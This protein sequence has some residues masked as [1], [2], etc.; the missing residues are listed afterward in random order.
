MGEAVRALKTRALRKEAPC[1]K[2]K[3]TDDLSDSEEETE[4]KCK[5]SK[6]D[7]GMK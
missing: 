3:K 2:P 5:K 4:S 1:N 7:K 6:E